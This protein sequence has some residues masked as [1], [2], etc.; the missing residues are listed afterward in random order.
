MD[1][2]DG[3]D[4]FPPYPVGNCQKNTNTCIL[5]IVSNMPDMLGG[6]SV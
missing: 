3:L 2:L 4:G 1:V 5:C 6:V